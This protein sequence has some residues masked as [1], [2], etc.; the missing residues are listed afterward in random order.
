LL[1]VQQTDQDLA[2]GRPCDRASH[3][4]AGQQADGGNQ[5]TGKA[6]HGRERRQ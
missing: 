3:A 4:S 1:A 6:D 5:G 2:I